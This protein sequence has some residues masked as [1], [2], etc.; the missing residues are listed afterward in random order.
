MVLVDDRERVLLFRCQ[1]DAATELVLPVGLRPL[2]DR[3]LA[4]ERPDP[5][6]QLPWRTPEALG[7]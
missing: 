6:I 5:P 2:L 4:G 3:L 7:T 1:I